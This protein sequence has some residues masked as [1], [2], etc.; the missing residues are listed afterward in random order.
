MP[1]M[2]ETPVYVKEVLAGDK[3][4][5]K[6]VVRVRTLPFAQSL[7]GSF[8]VQLAWFF[9]P[10]SNLYGFMSNNMQM[11]SSQYSSARLHTAK[12]GL[13]TSDFESFSGDGN[14][15]NAYKMNYFNLAA[16]NN[17]GT[18]LN[19]LGIPADYIP[20]F[21]VDDAA[22]TWN[23]H[24]LFTYLDIIR[25]YYVN[26]QFD[27][28]PFVTSQFGK[29]LNPAF[30]YGTLS[31][32]TLD[33]FFLWLRSQTYGV[34][35]SVL[36]S[37]LVQSLGDGAQSFLNYLDSITGGRGTFA[38]PIAKTDTET[39][40]VE[41]T[42]YRLAPSSGLFCANYRSDVYTRIMSDG[43]GFEATVQAGSG[44]KISYNSII[45]AS[46]LQAFINNFDVTGGRWSDMMR[47]RWGVDVNGQTD[48]PYLLS[49]ETIPLNISDM[50]T[51]SD[52]STG[53][54][55]ATQVGYIDV[56]DRVQKISFNASCSGTLM[57]IATIIP[58]IS[59]SED[60]EQEVL[61]GKFFDRYQPEF[62]NIAFDNIP[63][64][65]FS[66]LPMV[67]TY[68]DSSSAPVYV[69]YQSFTPSDSQ[70]RSVAW[71]NYMTDVNRSYGNLASGQNMESWILN[72][73][74]YKHSLQ[75]IDDP[76]TPKVSSRL[77]AAFAY[78]SYGL[79]TETN[80]AFVDTAVG[81]QNFIF[82]IG[83]D[84]QVRRAIPKYNLPKVY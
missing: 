65:A 83:L 12:I 64:S 32:S 41:G 7:M 80:Y 82:Q 17:S 5:I 81:S 78:S 72:R 23:L 20:Y 57:C 73:S 24:R 53:T 39:G 61:A 68:Y 11:N 26:R 34:D 30:S 3:W 13:S 6:P 54:P 77:Q 58:N 71:W 70:G 52:S 45:G 62:A 8:S 51:T 40:E 35:F 56:G 14:F 25:N 29:N 19:Y 67:N 46:R 31:L 49:V 33:N 76:E 15:T 2:L 22:P 74:F 79:P 59:Y 48:K 55:A 50:R 47:F 75:N 28:V 63:R 60:I 36:P 37:T 16:Q 84:I 21:N 4:R 18:L 9:E 10:D 69:D 44:L 27:A 38:K 42:Y 1:V 66:A 43:T